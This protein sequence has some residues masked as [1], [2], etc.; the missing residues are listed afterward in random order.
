MRISTEAHW[1]DDPCARCAIRNSSAN[2]T[3]LAAGVLNSC[4]GDVMAEGAGE[5]IRS[6]NVPVGRSD[7]VAT[8][9]T[10]R[11]LVGVGSLVIV[12]SSNVVKV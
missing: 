5:V 7:A 2:Q 6:T 1:H 10:G 11:I 12:I 9:R 8:A 3:A 4:S